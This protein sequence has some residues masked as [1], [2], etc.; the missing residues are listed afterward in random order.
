MKLV[1]STKGTVLMADGTRRAACMNTYKIQTNSADG[2]SCE[3]TYDTRVEFELFVN[4]NASG[5]RFRKTT[6][7]QASTFAK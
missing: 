1:A 7:K 2:T 5:R 4:A 3:T 6:A